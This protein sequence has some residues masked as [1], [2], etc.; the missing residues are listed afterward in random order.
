[1]FYTESATVKPEFED[2]FRRLQI[3]E[4][5][6]EL[7]DEQFASNPHTT[8]MLKFLS[9]NVSKTLITKNPTNEAIDFLYKN[10]QHIDWDFICYNNSTNIGTLLDIYKRSIQWGALSTN[11]SASPFLSTNLKKLNWF[12]FSCNPSD[13]ALDIME[14]YP[15]LINYSSL[16]GNPNPRALPLLL[17]N[18][19]KI[20]WVSFS[21]NPI[22]I[23]VLRDHLDQ[24]YWSELAYNPSPDALQLME[25]NIDKIDKFIMGTNPVAVPWLRKNMEY[26]NWDNICINARTPEA[27]QF[28][29]E[30]IEHVSWEYLSENTYAISILKEFPERITEEALYSQ[31]IFDIKTTYDYNGI[32]ESKRDLHQEY[33]AWAGHPSMILTKWKDWG[34]LE[35]E[36]DE[37]EEVGE[38]DGL[39]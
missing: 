29:R 28:I 37:L 31:D 11:P 27:I 4:I 13:H 16:S 25:E 6:Q 12:F 23:P 15:E 30:N 33:H 36:V 21:G 20:N 24:I 8:F 19:E 9:E 26:V 38:V 32:L 7:I 39:F 18:F 34:L 3:T 17:K 22:A 2:L 14:Q 1:M 10:P 35:V 5:T